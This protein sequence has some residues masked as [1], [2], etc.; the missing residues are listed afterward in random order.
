MLLLAGLHLSLA[1]SLSFTPNT[2]THTH[3]HAL[4][5][6]PRTDFVGRG[7]LSERQQKLGVMMSALKKLSEEFNIGG[8]P[9]APAGAGWVPSNH[10]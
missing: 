7:E 3:T 4:T 1:F 6:R 8:A 10:V 9:H 5:H 2:H